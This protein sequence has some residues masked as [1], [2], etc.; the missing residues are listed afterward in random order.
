METEH[1]YIGDEFADNYREPTNVEKQ[2]RIRNRVNGTLTSISFFEEGFVRVR[3]TR[4]KKLVKEHTLE[5]RFLSDEAVVTKRLALPFL[6]TALGVG[7]LALL[8]SFVLPM[9]GLAQFTISVTASLATIAVISLLLFVYRSDETHR[10]CTASGHT[11]VITLTGS[12]GCIRNVR[13]ASRE[14]S[15]AIREEAGG[16][17]T[18]DVRYLRAEMKV[19]YKLAE[20]GVIS[21]E[22]C[23]DG[24]SLILSKFG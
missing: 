11:P 20:M 13:S 16:Y 15:R 2:R 8:V 23:S 3:E 4:K 6:W 17:D 5:L 19:H 9:T 12:V 7:L 21:R 22:A 24:T 10:F 1:I 14:I 18:D